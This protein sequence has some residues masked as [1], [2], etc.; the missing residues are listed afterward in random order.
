MHGTTLETARPP[1]PEDFGLTDD[2][3]HSAPRTLFGAHR[4]AWIVG[5]WAGAAVAVLVALLVLSGSIAASLAFTVLAIAAASVLLV[6]GLTALVCG[7]EVCERCVLCRRHS[8]YAALI[9]Y[10]EA[11]DRFETG[12]RRRAAARV[13]SGVRFWTDLAPAALVAEVE[14]LFED[15]GSEVER[16]PEDRGAG[17][18]LVL[19]D[20][21]ARTAVRCQAEPIENGRALGHEMAGARLE[22]GVE[23]MVLVAPA[24]APAEL[25]ELLARH[26]GGVLDA[27]ALDRLRAP[28]L[29]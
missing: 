25:E 8:H 16:L 2:M 12:A 20:G 17:F 27:A 9:R 24:G 29:G 22:L 23:R 15:A 3:I 11:V 18:D 6:P 1:R 10:R 4:G 13:R 21:G 14:R 7:L 28:A 26:D 5:L 19:T